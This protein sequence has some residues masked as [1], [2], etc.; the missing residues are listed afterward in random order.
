FPQRAAVGPATAPR[1]LRLAAS[2]ERRPPT[3][4]AAAGRSRV[5]RLCLETRRMAFETF[6][7]SPCFQPTAFG[8]TTTYSATRTWLTVAPHAWERRATGLGAG[9][10]RSQPRSW[11]ACRRW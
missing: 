9:A 6:R 3:A 8:L 11:P 7:M 1:V 5:G 10:L 2:T 4:P